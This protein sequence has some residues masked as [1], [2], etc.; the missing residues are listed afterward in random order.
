MGF[1]KVQ[2]QD[3][4]MQMALCPQIVFLYHKQ[5]N[6]FSFVNHNADTIFVYQMLIVVIPDFHCPK[7]LAVSASSG[8][9]CLSLK[10]SCISSFL[11]SLQSAP[12]FFHLHSLKKLVFPLSFSSKK[13]SQKKMF[14]KGNNC[15]ISQMRMMKQMG[16]VE[17][18]H[19]WKEN[20]YGS[21]YS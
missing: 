8:L 20:F 9:I 13:M 6:L 19:Q 3:W 5:K 17:S 16:Q 1:L 11:K 18:I 12:P 7:F 4:R 2:I 15:T 21:D 10:L 14:N